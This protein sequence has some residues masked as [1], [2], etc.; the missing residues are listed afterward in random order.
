MD[1]T[2]DQQTFDIDI[3]CSLSAQER[4][5]RGDTWAQVLATAESVAELDD[6]YAL[7]FPNHDAWIA[8]AASLIV[9]ERKC[10]PFFGFA[11]EFQPDN[12]PVW[13]HI[14]GPG[15][16]KVFIRNQMVPAHVR[17]SA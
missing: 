16:V 9:A 4:A 5:E 13:M 7:R 2:L 6:G 11:L 15:E 10:C 1:T 8:R 3:A 17:T 12:G 14:K